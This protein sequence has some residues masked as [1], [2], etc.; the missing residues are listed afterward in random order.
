MN[1][2]CSKKCQ[3][4]VIAA[5]R[6]PC[7]LHDA[8]RSAMTNLAFRRDIA[9]HLLRATPLQ[10]LRP[11]QINTVY[12]FHE[13][14]AVYNIPKWDCICKIKYSLQLDRNSVTKGFGKACE[15]RMVKWLEERENIIPKHSSILDLGCGNASLLLNLAKRGYSNL[16]GIDY[17][18]SAI[19][20]AQAKANREKLNQIHFQNLDLMIN[21]ENLHN[22]FDVILDKGTFDV[23]SLREDAEKAVP[24][25]KSWTKNI[26]QQSTLEAK[27]ALR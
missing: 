7:E 25:S 19:Q 4:P 9:A 2:N 17:S 21:S 11:R 24:T 20:L 3:L 13:D 12:C 14:T 26:S 8:D 27:L 22:K 15:L 5:W 10:I 18:D 23:I 16:T 6:L 1:E